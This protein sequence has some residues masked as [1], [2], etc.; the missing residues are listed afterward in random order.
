[1]EPN[2]C[3]SSTPESNFTTTYYKAS[4]NGGTGTLGLFSDSACAG[5]STPLTSNGGCESVGATSSKITCSGS[6]LLMVS[7]TL[8]A[9]L[10]YLI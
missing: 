10:F 7:V 9:A 1:M 6:S 5:Q 3:V 8:I 2:L 4:C